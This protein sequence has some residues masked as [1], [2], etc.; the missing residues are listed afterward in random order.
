MFETMVHAGLTHHLYGQSFQPPLGEAGYERH[1]APNRRPY[2]TKDGYLCAVII[3]DGRWR[4]FFDMVGRPELKTDPRFKDVALRF[5]A[6]GRLFLSSATTAPDRYGQH[7]D[8]QTARSGRLAF[9]C[10]R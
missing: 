4:R 8:Q 10:G 9:L 6:G 2:A 5:P 7:Q 3:T 1:I